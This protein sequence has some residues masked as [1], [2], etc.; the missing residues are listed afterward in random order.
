MTLLFWTLNLTPRTTPPR[1]AQELADAE[2]RAAR[3]GIPLGQ[4]LVA[5]RA[6]ATRRRYE[7]AQLA[8]L[9]AAIAADS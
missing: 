3:D 8:A 5:I 9:R 7:D 4:A 2:A 6:E 1:P